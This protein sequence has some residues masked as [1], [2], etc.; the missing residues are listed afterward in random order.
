[1]DQ[2]MRDA[3]AF[4][5][6]RG[7]ALVQ[8]RRAV[9]LAAAPKPFAGFLIAEGDSWL[10]YPIFDEITEKLEDD[11]AYSIESAA[12]WGD[13][14]DNILYTHG[15]DG[16]QIVKVFEKVKKDGHV[17]RAIL[18]SCGGNDIAGDR[19][20]HLLNHKNSPQPGLNQPI[21]DAVFTRLGA[22]IAGVVGLLKQLGTQH[23]NKDVPVVLHGYGYSVP[24]GRGFLDSSWFSGPWLA[25]A[26]KEK[27]Y[28]DVADRV[29]I[30][31]TLIDRFN[32]IMQTIA[33]GVP[34][35]VYV[36]ARPFLSNVL[37][38]NRY[39]DDWSNELHPTGDGFRKVADLIDTAIKTFPM[40]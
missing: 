30:T 32:A 21:V 36:N 16:K 2:Q 23:F 6:D 14:A 24:D 5:Q 28:S 31:A 9:S 15:G 13:T 8:H 25:P 20:I 39:Q 10:N 26:F 11:H 18:L 40:P 19:F 7:K 17:P 35:V 12:R 1:M 29:A 37:A 38:N 27:G 34:N 33:N 3:F 4:G 22:T